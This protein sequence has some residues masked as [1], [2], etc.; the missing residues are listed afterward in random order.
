MQVSEHPLNLTKYTATISDVSKRLSTEAFEGSP[1]KILNAINLPLP[2]IEGTRG[3]IIKSAAN[4]F[5]DMKGCISCHMQ[6]P[7]FGSQ[8]RR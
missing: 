3:M 1:V 4:K 2:D 7:N 6:E 5:V 8:P